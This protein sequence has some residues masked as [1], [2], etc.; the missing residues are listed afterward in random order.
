MYIDEVLYLFIAKNQSLEIGQLTPGTH[1]IIIKDQDK[2]LWQS[3]FDITADSIVYLTEKIS[4]GIIAWD[5]TYGG[6]EADNGFSIIQTTDGGFAITGY[7]E[8]KGAGK[9]DIWVL[10]LDKDGNLK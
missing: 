10:K 8:S 4:T 9:E 2:I 7:T 6:S 3:D 1:N 5:K